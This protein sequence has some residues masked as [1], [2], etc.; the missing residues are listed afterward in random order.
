MREEKLP[1]HLK[2][3][4]LIAFFK[5][6]IEMEKCPEVITTERDLT[7]N[8]VIDKCLESYVAQSFGIK[9]AECNIWLFIHLYNGFSEL[10]TDCRTKMLLTVSQPNWLVFA[11]I[12][13]AVKL[14]FLLHLKR[15][16][17]RYSFSG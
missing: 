9:T 8:F 3:K 1:E 17:V 12:L 10:P 14:C 2:G 15:M 16:I 13:F 6:V 7:D 5:H 11:F 4:T